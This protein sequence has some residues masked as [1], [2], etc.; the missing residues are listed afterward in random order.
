M[1]IGTWSFQGVGQSVVIYETVHL[2]RDGFKD[3][4]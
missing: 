1:Y 2:F 4:L 3:Q